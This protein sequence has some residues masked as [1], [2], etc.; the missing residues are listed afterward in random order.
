VSLQDFHDAYLECL[1]W[2]SPVTDPDDP[3]GDYLHADDID[4]ELAPEAER[5]AAEDCAAF[6]DDN[7]ETWRAD[8]GWTDAQA[9]H[10]FALT[11]N[12]HG[13]GFWD[14]YYGADDPRAA[15]GTALAN[16][17]KPYGPADLYIGDD[18][19]LYL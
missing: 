3:D 15:A 12:G 10:D 7:A 17:C 5:A 1:L 16:A 14:R 18:G 13:A 9:G 6:Y 19:L 8:D 2:S 4:A 11:R